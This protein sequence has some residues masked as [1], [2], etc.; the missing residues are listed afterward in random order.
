[1]EAPGAFDQVVEDLRDDSRVEAVGRV[2]S[3]S[4]LD[5]LVGAQE[6][7]ASEEVSCAESDVGREENVL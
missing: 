3:R 7:D 5:L 2:G 6:E 4:R 1:M